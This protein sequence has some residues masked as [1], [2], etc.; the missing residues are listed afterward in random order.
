MRKIKLTL[1]MGILAILTLTPSCSKSGGSNQLLALSA[2]L[3]WTNTAAQYIVPRHSSFPR[4]VQEITLR[5]NGQVG[6]IEFDLKDPSGI[7]QATP[8]SGVLSPGQQIII[9]VAI[10]AL[11]NYK[12]EE[13][14]MTCRYAGALSTE[15]LVVAFAFALMPPG[16]YVMSLLS[17]SDPAI[18]NLFELAL[19]LGLVDAIVRHI[20]TNR[21]ADH[22]PILRFT[23]II[24]MGMLTLPLT[25]LQLQSNFWRSKTEPESNVAV[26]FPPGQGAIGYTLHPDMEVDMVPG[27]FHVFHSWMRLGGVIPIKDPEPK[28]RHTYAFVLDSDGSVTNNWKARPTYPNHFWQ[29]TDRWYEI[30]YNQKD[31]PGA[32][33]FRVWQVDATGKASQVA[34]AARAIIVEDAIV[35]VV[36]K[37]EI[38]GPSATWRTTTFVHQTDDLGGISPFLWSGDVEPAISKPMHPVK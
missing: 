5:H 2:A 26:N 34:S 18:P 6:D 12:T 32:W 36:P 37:S 15:V 19:L 10:L 21:K 14:L 38:P 23:E 35:L 28:N 27:D 4:D 7:L 3:V 30:R 31:T 29:G 9:T 20:G 16:M 25:F 33:S 24:L 1:A 13:L 11:I 8:A 22:A 17:A